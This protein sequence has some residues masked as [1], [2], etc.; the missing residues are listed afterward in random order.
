MKDI[1]D[2]APKYDCTSCREWDNIKNILIK[3][4]PLKKKFKSRE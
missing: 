2:I 3:E 4:N 1:C